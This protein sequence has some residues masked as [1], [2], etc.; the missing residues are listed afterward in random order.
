MG[1]KGAHRRSPECSEYCVSANRMYRRTR[2][3]APVAMLVAA[4]NL[5]N[6]FEPQT[7]SIRRANKRMLTTLKIS[8]DVTLYKLRFFFLIEI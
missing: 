4:M 5:M 7:G 2:V 1:G 3:P 8:C 6:S